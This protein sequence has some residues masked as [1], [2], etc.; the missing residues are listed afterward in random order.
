MAQLL[1]YTDVMAKGDPFIRLHLNLEQP[2]ELTDFVGTFLSLASQFEDYMKRE[3]GDWDVEAKIYVTQITPGSIIADLAPFVTTIIDLMDKAM[4]VEDFVRQ[5]GARISAYFSIGGRD[6][7][8]SKGD[9][10]DVMDAV[11]AIAR[12]PN[13]SSRIEAVAFE[14]NKTRVRA[15]FKFNTKQARVAREQAEAHKE[16]LNRRTKADHERVLMWFKRSDKD[17]SDIGKRSGERVVIEEISDADLPLIYAS[18]LAEQRIKHE[19]R[20]PSVNIFTRGF[21]VDVNV[22]L[23]SGRPV[24]YAVTNVHQ[25]IDLPEP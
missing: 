4:I 23:K 5:Y 18:E 21:V 12:D 22:Q 10:K 9:L 15:A 6:T 17:D 1:S 20:D 24:A 8:A 16:E 19:T 11:E 2:A 3:R 25:V 14:K 13:G 7:S